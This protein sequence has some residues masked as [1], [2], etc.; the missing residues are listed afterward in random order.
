MTSLNSGITSGRCWGNIYY[1][2]AENFYRRC[3]HSVS[4]VKYSHHL[5]VSHSPLAREQYVTC[6]CHMH[7]L[8]VT[9]V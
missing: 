2:G 3:N 5:L 6:L 7:H 9:H 8:Q 4:Q 1:I